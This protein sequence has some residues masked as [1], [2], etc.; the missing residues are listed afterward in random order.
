MH[1]STTFRYSDNPDE[2][3][4]WADMDVS[5]LVSKSPRSRTGLTACS[6]TR[7]MSRTFTPERSRQTQLATKRS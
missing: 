2:L 7:S 6:P 4:P 1:V 3:L 5:Y